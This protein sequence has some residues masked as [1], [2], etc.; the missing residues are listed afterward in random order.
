M[1]VIKDISLCLSRPPKTVDFWLSPPESYPEAAPKREDAPERLV[2]VDFEHP[3]NRVIGRIG[4]LLF[5][6]DQ[7]N[8]PE[9]EVKPVGYAS[10]TTTK[11]RASA[12]P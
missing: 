10:L 11:G 4:S 3:K 9:R 7:D 2:D 1:G 12:E 6:Y 5:P 8:Y